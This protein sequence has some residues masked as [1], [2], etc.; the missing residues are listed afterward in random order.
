MVVNMKRLKKIGK[1]RVK[2]R[3]ISDRVNMETEQGKEE[4]DK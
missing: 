3:K 4:K 2:R 1:D